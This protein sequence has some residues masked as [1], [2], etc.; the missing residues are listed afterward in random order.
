MKQFYT[1]P[2]QPDICLLE[3][4][5]RMLWKLKKSGIFSVHSLHE[6]IWGAPTNSFPRK[7]VWCTKAPKRVSFFVWTITWGKILTCDNLIKRGFSLVGW[8]CMCKC[9]WETVSHLLVHCEFFMTY[10]ALFSEHLGFI[11]CYQWEWLMFWLHGIGVGSTLQ[12]LWILYHYAWC[13]WVEELVW[14]AL[15]E[16][17]EFCTIMLDVAIMEG[18]N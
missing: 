14:E 16:Y 12:I 7:S 10:E 15:F 4:S 2:Y 17:Y 11:G 1:N 8:C 3:G 13:G 18:A 9:N 5:D 6:A